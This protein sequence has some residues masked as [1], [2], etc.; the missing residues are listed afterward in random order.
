G[1]TRAATVNDVLLCVLD[2]ALR[3]YLARSSQEPATPLV[4][5]M[6]VALPAEGSHGNRIAMVQVRLGEPGLAANRRLDRIVAQT[7]AV[8]GQRQ[9]AASGPAMIHSLVAH[10]LP[11]LF[12]ALR[13]DKA[14]LLA[15]LVVSNPFGFAE[16]RYLMG[17]EVELL[18]PVSLA[19][20]GQVL[21]ITGVNYGDRYQIAFLAI[22][23]AVPDIELLAQYTEEAFAELAPT[24]GA[25]RGEA[26]T[27]KR[28]RRLKPVT[29]RR[30]RS[31]S[32][33]RRSSA[34]RLA[35]SSRRLA[36]TLRSTVAIKRSKR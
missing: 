32:A 25:P 19:A 14:P 12:E 34:R 27:S 13:V 20:P 23:E 28:R 18:L 3:R 6:P 16:R 30:V 10:G 22:A 24:T 15:N 11:G 8:R 29:G 17:A 31:P 26:D 1:K 2:I 9:G 33:R 21:N 36:P 35:D 7:R 4:V 5:D